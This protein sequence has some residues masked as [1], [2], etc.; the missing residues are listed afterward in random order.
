[1]NT[2]EARHLTVFVHRA[3]GGESWKLVAQGSW[4]PGQPPELD[5]V[6]PIEVMDLFNN[7]IVGR[8]QAGEGHWDLHDARYRITWHQGP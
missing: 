3:V 1:M 6:L 5:H 2:I 7:A 4:Q 8:E